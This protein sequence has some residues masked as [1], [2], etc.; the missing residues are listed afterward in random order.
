MRADIHVGTQAGCMR[1][2]ENSMMVAVCSDDKR[3]RKG[4]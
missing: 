2:K 4:E 1:A 3:R